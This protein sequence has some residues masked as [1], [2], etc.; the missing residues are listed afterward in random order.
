MKS[1]EIQI[2]EYLKATPATTEAI[3]LNALHGQH[4]TP[5]AVG[6]A[7]ARLRASGHIET[8]NGVHYAK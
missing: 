7:V 2:L 1:I 8:I 3:R 4:A 5:K 6:N